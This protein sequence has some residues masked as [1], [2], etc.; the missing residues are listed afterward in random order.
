L[1]R[2]PSSDENID[3]RGTGISST[4]N[5]DIKKYEGL[6]RKGQDESYRGQGNVK[7]R[8]NPVKKI[9]LNPPLIKG[10]LI[11]PPFEKGG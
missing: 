8:L 7:V 3:V 10:D 5:L 4:A 1:H 2:A 9:P 11:F 6:K